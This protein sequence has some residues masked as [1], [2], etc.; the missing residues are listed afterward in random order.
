MF[1]FSIHLIKAGTLIELV[2]KH[3][4]TKVKLLDLFASYWEKTE[5]QELDNGEFDFYIRF[6]DKPDDTY[7]YCFKDEGFHFIY[8]RF[9][10]EDYEDFG[11]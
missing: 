1:H 9:L 11:F 6:L 2:Q 10:P 7:Y 4:C 5:C 3:E 8:H